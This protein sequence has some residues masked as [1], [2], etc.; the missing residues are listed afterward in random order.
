M[1]TY[2]IR[3]DPV[4]ERKGLKSWGVFERV[5]DGFERGL[6]QHSTFGEALAAKAALERGDSE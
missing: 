6:S 4:R 5:S 2:T 3:H 1:K